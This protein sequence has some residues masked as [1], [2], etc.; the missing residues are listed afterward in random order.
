MESFANRRTIALAAL[1]SV[2][3]A[4][5][6]TPVHAQLGGLRRAVE[7]RVEQKAEDRVAVGKLIE[8]TFDATTV[9]ITGERLDRYVAALERRNAQRAQ[10]QQAYTDM[11]N[12]VVATRDSAAALR[13]GP[14]MTAYNTAV[15]RY[16]ECRSGVQREL[17]QRQEQ[18]GAALQAR[19]QSNPMA[20]QSDPKMKA[21]M[22]SMQEISAA[23]QR[24][25]T[26]AVRTAQ[27]RMF[28]A[29]GIPLTDSASVD[30]AA[31]SRCGARPAVP[32]SKLRAERLS[33]RTDSLGRELAVLGGRGRGIAGSEVGMTDAQSRMFWERVASWLN[34]MRDG[35]PVTLTFSRAEYDLLVARRGD[36]RKAF[37][38][39]E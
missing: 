35:A 28:A 6:S 20:A 34:G 38:G 7:R 27:E 33:A 2:S 31:V 12:R 29:M 9:E 5:V 15:N 11:N 36:L 30:K 22:A 8:P 21:M 3:L 17:N 16:S 1:F 18:Q 39:G 14:E 19:F 24:G 25:D 23:S 32:A 4:A 10:R 37:N 26:V 13:D